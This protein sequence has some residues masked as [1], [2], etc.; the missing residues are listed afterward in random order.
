MVAAQKKKWEPLDLRSLPDCS[1]L[2]CDPSLTALGL[3]WLDVEDGEVAIRGAEKLSTAPTE[4]KGWEDTFY[5]VQ[6]MEA[7]IAALMDHWSDVAKGVNFIGVHESPPA[8]G[9]SLMRTESSILTGY[10]FRSVMNEYNID[11]DQSVTPQSHKKL[12]SGNHIATKKFHHD[13]V[14]L[15]L[16]RIQDSSL[17]TNEATRDALSIGL[18]AAWRKGNGS[19]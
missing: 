18:Y 3:V 10:A 7:L 4:R 8:G 9:G 12:I 6:L 17:I 5:R 16:P 19:V 2:A 11:I 13:A 14:K 15:L 1:Y